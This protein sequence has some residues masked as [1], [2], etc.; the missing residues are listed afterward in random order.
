MNI[1]TWAVVFA[2]LLGPVLAVQAQRVVSQ[3]QERRN[4]KLAIFRSL[5]NTRV[6]SLSAEHV[7]AFNSVPL[8]FHGD[9]EVMRKW[10]TYLD[11]L[12]QKDMAMEVWAPRR[13]DLNTELLE[14]MAKSLKYKFDPVQ[15]KKEIYAP[16][17]HARLESEQELI[18][19]GVL[20]LFT[21]ER[22]LP[23]DVR[24]FPVDEDAAKNLKEL[25][26]L[27]L[28]WLRGKATPTVRI[29][30]KDG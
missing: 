30:G 13:W 16:E 6:T 28:D 15:L 9:D 27:M 4:R 1:D 11:H 26:V 22:A 12:G 3:V 8:E 14:A 19:R 25:H 18:R 24:G 21:G 10:R 5:M 2:T 23:M 17:G 29:E 7:Q 20:A